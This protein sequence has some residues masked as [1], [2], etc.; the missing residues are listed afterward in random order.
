MNIRGLG[1]GT[2]V[3]YMRRCISFEKVEFVCLQETKTTV[4]TDTR[5]FSMCGDNKIGWIHNEGDNGNG[6]LLSMWHKEAFSY[7]SHS[8]G[9]GYIATVGQHLKSGHRCCVVNVY[10]AC[11]LKEKKLLWEELSNYKVVSQIDVWCF[12]GD[13]N[14]IRSRNERK[15]L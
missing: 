6:S 5:C 13:F 9:K 12:C 8:M 7:E 1:G 14:A 11:T 10:A 2:K 15:E 4:V 3:R